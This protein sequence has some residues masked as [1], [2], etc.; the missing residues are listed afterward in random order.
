MKRHIP[1]LHSGHKIAE[2]ISKA[3]SWCASNGANYRWHPQKPC[4][5]I[6]FA[7]LEPDDLRT[8]L[9][10]PPLLHPKAL[11]RLSWFLRDFGYDT[12]LLGRDQVDE[13]ALIAS[14]SRPH[15]AKT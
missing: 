10:R 4:F 8:L 14:G 5:L 1:G 15:F 12:D 6:R 7:V 13:K 9:L 11:W 2:D 3:C